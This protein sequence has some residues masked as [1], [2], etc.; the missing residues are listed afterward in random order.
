MTIDDYEEAYRLWT[1]TPGMGLRSLD[2]S[3]E[4]IGR[5]LKRNGTT[6]FVCRTDAGLGGIILC[7]H[8]GRRGYI[9]HMAVRPDCRRRGIGRELVRLALDSLDREGIAKAALVV[10]ESNEEGNRFWESLGFG[11]RQDLVYR[12]RVIDARNQ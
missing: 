1:S 2:D 6:N 9:Y 12:N 11:A 5:F 10:F 3:R 4:G 7:G 8:D